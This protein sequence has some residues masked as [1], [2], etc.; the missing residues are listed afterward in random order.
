MIHASVRFVPRTLVAVVKTAIDL[1]AYV[2]LAFGLYGTVTVA[3]AIV[4]I[5]FA[6]QL[7]PQQLLA[8]AVTDSFL[9]VVT[10][11]V[12][13]NVVAE[14]LFH[15]WSHSSLALTDISLAPEHVGSIYVPS[16][17]SGLAIVLGIRAR[18]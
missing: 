8:E 1:L 7:D 5:P 15:W 10:R 17:L 3:L 6:V 14:T 16:I 18:R 4:L 2:A 13:Q 9:H 11:M 12:L